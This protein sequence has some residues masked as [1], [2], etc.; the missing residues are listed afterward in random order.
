MKDRAFE[1]ADIGYLESAARSVKAEVVIPSDIR[2]AQALKDKGI[3]VPGLLEPKELYLLMKIV[4][5]I[6]AGADI[7]DGFVVYLNDRGVTNIPENDVHTVLYR[8]KT[9][10]FNNLMGAVNKMTSDLKK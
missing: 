5:R 6:K 1:T 3:P 7:P 8:Q 10:A 9:V 4:E 2:E